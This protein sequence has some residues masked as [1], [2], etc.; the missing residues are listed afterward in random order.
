MLEYA[1]L[2]A[3]RQSGGEFVDVLTILSA[4]RRRAQIDMQAPSAYTI[5]KRMEAEGL[6]FRV[7]ESRPK[8]E[9]RHFYTLTDAGFAFITLWAGRI[10]ALG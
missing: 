10:V 8:G 1:L 9:S 5:L 7:E 2:C 4:L 3:I 6:V